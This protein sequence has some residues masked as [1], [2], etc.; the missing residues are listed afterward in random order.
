[1]PK[2]REKKIKNRKLCEFDVENLKIENEDPHQRP[3]DEGSPKLEHESHH[4]QKYQ[5][6][7]DRPFIAP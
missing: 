7:N 1:M 4:R 2:P 6:G 5:A 3:A